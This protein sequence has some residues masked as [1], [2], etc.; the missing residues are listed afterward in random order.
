MSGEVT[1][2][3]F[4]YG[5]ADA[6]TQA[7]LIIAGKSALVMLVE[8]A[9]EAG[10]ESVPLAEIEKNIAIM[11]VEINKRLAVL[12]TTEEKANP[13]DDIPIE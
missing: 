8:A 11:E 2:G 13:P 5:N 3:E 10:R 12:S 6:N 7:W 9:R 4:H 1:G